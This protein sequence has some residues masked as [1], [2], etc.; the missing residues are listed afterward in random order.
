MKIIYKF[1]NSSDILYNKQDL[2]EMVIKTLK[3]NITQNFPETIAQEYVEKMPGYIEDGSAIIV[4]AFHKEQ[5]IGFLLGYEVDIFGEKRIH[6]TEIHVKEEYRRYGIAKK[7]LGWLEIEA[8]RRNIYILEAM[9]TVSNQDA[10]RYHINNGY[11]IERIKFKK[12]LNK[13]DIKEAF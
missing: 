11:E 8:I 2:V 10:Y 3:E 7:M 4:G 9:C 6:T 5:L 12:S 13:N 1:L